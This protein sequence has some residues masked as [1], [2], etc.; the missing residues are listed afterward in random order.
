MDKI[1]LAARAK[2]A[3]STSTSGPAGGAKG[4]WD[5]L[6]THRTAAVIADSDNVVV[7]VRIRPLNSIELGEKNKEVS[8]LGCFIGILRQHS[9]FPGI[10]LFP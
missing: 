4:R 1:V 5:K 7:G 3:P 10:T 2:N 9:L 8:V 6:K